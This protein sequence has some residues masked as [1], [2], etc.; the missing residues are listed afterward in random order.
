MRKITADIIFPVATPPVKEG[1][2][3]VDDEGKV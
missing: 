2:I 3:V 1:V